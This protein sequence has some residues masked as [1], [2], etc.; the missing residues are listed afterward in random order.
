M[1]ITQ[2]DLST[3]ES[4]ESEV[5]SYCRGWPTVFDRAQG[6]RCT[7]RTAMRTSTSSPVP[8][9]STTATTTRCSNGR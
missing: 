4:L 1:T 3:F 7:T 6:S 9:H 2:P 8:D 5:R